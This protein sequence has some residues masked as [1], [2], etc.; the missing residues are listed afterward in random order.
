MSGTPQLPPNPPLWARL[1]V[2]TGNVIQ[3]AGLLLG[4]AMLYFAGHT[5]AADSV[6]IV[7]MILAWAV[8]YICCHSFG[9]YVIG[10]LVGI[11]FR[12]YGIRG[13]DH[14]ESYPAGMRQVMSAIP[15]FTAMTEKPSMAKASPIAK[16]LMFAAGETSTTVC[17]VAAGWYAWH[18]EIPGGGILFIV[19]IVFCALAIVTAFFPKGDYAK[20]LRA[21][22]NG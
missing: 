20:A 15:F 10:R 6:R 3:L 1:S 2:T 11:R 22:R 9:H 12:G 18:K 19:S 17:C 13:T 14:P 5:S 7:L 16:A 4:A 8:I 21:L